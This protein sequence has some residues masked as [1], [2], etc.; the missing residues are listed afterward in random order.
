MFNLSEAE[1]DGLVTSDPSLHFGFL[2]LAG[3]ALIAFVITLLTVQLGDR[4]FAT[5]VA[6]TTVSAIA[7]LYF[8]LRSH[9]AS[10]ASQQRI[11]R[12]KARRVPQ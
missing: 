11:N 5:F 6:L 10:K 2:G 8:G 12:I 3:G 1:L 4:L 7:T 9:K